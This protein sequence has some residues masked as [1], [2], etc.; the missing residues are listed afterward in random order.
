MSVP[1]YDIRPRL[2]NGVLFPVIFGLSL[3]AGV[4]AGDRSDS[5]WVGL[6]AFLVAWKC[7]R[8]IRR[9]VRGLLVDALHAALW[10]AGAAGFAWLFV[11]AGTAEVDRCGPRDARRRGR[12][13]RRLAAAAEAP[14]ARRAVRVVRGVGPAG[15]GRRDPGPLHPQGG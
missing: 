8:V 6:L 1:A 2:L 10:P 15:G 4:V 12:E 3:A 7:G 11:W 5:F 13:G 14:Q 9:L